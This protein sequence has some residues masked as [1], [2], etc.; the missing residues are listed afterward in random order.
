MIVFEDSKIVAIATGLFRKSEN[1]KTGA[2]VQIWILTKALNPVEA[3]KTG[4]DRLVCGGCPM[5]PILGG[6]CYVIISQAPLNV[7]R[8]WQRGGYEPFDLSAFEGRFVRFGAYGEPV[9]IPI[10]RLADIADV[11][12]GWTGYTHQ[13]QKISNAVY[14]PYL[15]ASCNEQNWRQAILAGWRPFIISRRHINGA[16][17]C[18]ASAER[19]Y[20]LTC[21]SCRL[22]SGRNSHSSRAIQLAPHGASQKRIA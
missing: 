21:N 7:W 5:R 19:N 10:A 8:K 22:C 1:T 15:M 2:A 11:A 4:L 13:W 20:R 14:S 16:I 17:V 9:L 12:S 18:P 3:A 6:G